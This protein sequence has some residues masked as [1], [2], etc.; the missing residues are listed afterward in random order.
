MSLLVKLPKN[1]K[2]KINHRF[3]EYCNADRKLESIER[4]FRTCVG[5]SLVMFVVF[6]FDMMEPLILSELLGNSVVKAVQLSLL[7]GV[8]L[9]IFLQDKK[10]KTTNDRF[11]FSNELQQTWGLMVDRNST[12]GYSTSMA[13]GEIEGRWEIMQID[14]EN[15]DS[16]DDITSEDWQSFRNSLP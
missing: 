6:S 9:S 13:V 15:E 12:G 5:F 10:T 11:N 4:Q 14:L 2:V 16:Y 7:L 1:D 3:S 8:A